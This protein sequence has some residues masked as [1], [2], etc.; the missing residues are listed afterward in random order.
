M[1]SVRHLLGRRLDFPLPACRAHPRGRRAAGQHRQHGANRPRKWR[2][3][4]G[5]PSTR[6]AAR[7]L[8]GEDRHHRVGPDSLQ[9][10]CGA[11][12]A[13]VVNAAASSSDVV[14]TP[15]RQRS[16]A[17]ARLET[18]YGHAGSRW[19]AAS[20]A[21]ASGL[22]RQGHI[23]SSHTAAITASPAR[24]GAGRK[25]S[26]PWPPGRR[27]AA[28]GRVF[29][30]TWPASPWCQSLT[31]EDH[32]GCARMVPRPSDG[33]LG[34]SPTAA[35]RTLTRGRKVPSDGSTRCG[36]KGEGN[37]SQE[38]VLATGFVMV[39]GLITVGAAAAPEER[40]GSPAGYR[41]DGL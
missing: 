6:S 22:P 21:S 3:R 18:V 12:P 23:G 40:S 17:T 25:P 34:C 8:W 4:S 28:E 24:S 13:A 41:P 33:L 32:L 38:D 19:R 5:S 30:A 2:R 31:E 36:R 27:Q 1:R 20:A 11:R 10:G 9:G 39:A 14:V 26:L 7:R 15:Q 16:D 37:A 29:P 35:W